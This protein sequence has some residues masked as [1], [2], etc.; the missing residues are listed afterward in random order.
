[1]GRR[2]KLTPP[3]DASPEEMQAWLAKGMERQSSRASRGRETGEDRRREEMIADI[4]NR[5]AFAIAHPEL[6]EEA[7]VTIEDRTK[8]Y[9]LEVVDGVPRLVPRS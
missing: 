2:R 5:L 1:M 6:A 9:D 8:R 7:G 3:V 4:K